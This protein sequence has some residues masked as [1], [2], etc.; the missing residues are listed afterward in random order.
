MD[1]RAEEE[2][3]AGGV[4]NAGAVVR[5]DDTVRRPGG[6]AA[7]QVRLF[8][9]HLHEVGFTGAPRF[10]GLDE[11]GREILDYLDGDVA[12]P[13]YPRLGGRQGPIKQ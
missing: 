10:R 4:D 11:H 1:S 7:A 2:P 13:P 8:L 6:P 5:V 9:T 3:L 12:I